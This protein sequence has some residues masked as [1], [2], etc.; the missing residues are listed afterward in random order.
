MLSL[1]RINRKIEAEICPK[2]TFETPK[3]FKV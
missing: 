2:E 3:V 1:A